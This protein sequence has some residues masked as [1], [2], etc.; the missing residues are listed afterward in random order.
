MAEVSGHTGNVALAASSGGKG[1]LSA[2]QRS[3]TLNYVG[4]ALET[5]DFGSSG[6]REFIAGLTGWS[7]TFD[8]NWDAANKVVPGNLQTITLTAASGDTYVGLCL[9]TGQDTTVAVDALN[10][11]T[12]TF[13]GTGA[14][15]ITL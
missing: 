4:E 7:G 10:T 15:T 9:V 8:L 11:Q 13:Q 1:T 3:W 6:L 2:G 12:I 5:T 14:L